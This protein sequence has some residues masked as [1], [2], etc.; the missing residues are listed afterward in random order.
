MRL[1][2][3]TDEEIGD[4]IAG[5]LTIELKLPARDVRARAVHAQPS[6]VDA[7]FERVYAAGP[8]DA[9]YHLPGLADVEIREQ[10]AVAHGQ[11]SG[12][13]H[14]HVSR[15]ERRQAAWRQTCAGTGADARQP[16]RLRIEIR[17]GAGVLA[18]NPV[19]VEAELGLI[20]QGRAED[21]CLTEHSVA[22]RD[23]AVDRREVIDRDGGEVEFEEGDSGKQL[24]VVAE[25]VVA[26]SEYLVNVIQL[27]IDARQ[28]RADTRKIWQRVDVQIAA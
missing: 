12:D 8:R 23:A 14:G 5:Y 7:R 6:E 15:L 10:V 24:V 22:G 11:I 1:R 28:I 19:A 4:G 9:V 17:V 26:A 20:D 21:V 16:D 25:A 3:I 18:E 13:R 27:L 2:R